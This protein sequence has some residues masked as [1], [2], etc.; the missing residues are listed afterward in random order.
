MQTTISL[1]KVV[2]GTELSI[3]QE[4]IPEVIPVEACYLGWQES[5]IL[6]AK[7]VKAEIPG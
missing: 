7:L 5:L 3:L 2:V 4:G 1:R 6:L